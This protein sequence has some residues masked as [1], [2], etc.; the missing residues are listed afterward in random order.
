MTGQ[1]QDGW[2]GS[3]GPGWP[4]ARPPWPPDMAAP[5]ASAPAPAAP[6]Q[7][8]VS[9]HQGARQIPILC[10]NCGGPA[11]PAWDGS[12][13]CPYC[14][15]RDQL[16]ADELGRALEL[17]RRVAAAAEGV[18][19]LRGLES[20]LGHVFES[21]AA[22]LRAS[23][24]WFFVALFVAGYALFSAREIIAAA[25][26]GFRA[27]LIVN[28][29]IGPSF[30]AGVGLAICLALFIGRVSYRRRVRHLLFA[31]APREPGHPTRC[32]ACD[33][34]LPDRREA[35]VSCEYCNTQ[36][37]VTPEIQRDRER[38]LAAEVA[39]YRA[40]AQGALAATTR[41][42]I[43]M[44]RIFTISVVAV[45]GGMIGLAYLA[46]SLVPSVH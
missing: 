10:R 34:D 26:P 7:T 30:V 15:H 17:K 28:S 3:G 11:A 31:R 25:P 18:A 35:F 37:L 33:G 45:Y 29:L 16:P 8:G 13:A 44:S 9:P 14:G 2:G 38:L 46:Q 4:P 6:W 39:F 12:I 20:A 40:R 43:H 41:G 5:P 1:G 32:R 27:T 22:F 21:R 24:L 23:G 42:S 36:N 19:Q